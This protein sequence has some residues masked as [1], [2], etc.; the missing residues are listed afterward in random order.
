MDGLRFA[1]PAKKIKIERL[2]SSIIIWTQKLHLG[3]SSRG[4][5]SP[6]Y[7]E[8]IHHTLRRVLLYNCFYRD[9]KKS[10]AGKGTSEKRKNH[11]LH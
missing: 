8:W 4:Y 6:F 3:E 2:Q 1:S 5:G 9:C 7:V 10:A 11:L